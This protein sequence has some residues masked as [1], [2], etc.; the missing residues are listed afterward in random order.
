MNAVTIWGV[1]MFDVK[2]NT[3]TH[4]GASIHLLITVNCFEK[5]T[6]PLFALM[7]GEFPEYRFGGFCPRVEVESRSYKTAKTF[8]KDGYPVNFHIDPV[9]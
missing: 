2:L 4:L 5:A 3:R 7:T 6:V 9:L 1:S 8:D